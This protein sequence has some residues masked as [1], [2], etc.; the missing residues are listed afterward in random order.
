MKF[1][2][3]SKSLQSKS[4]GAVKVFNRIVKTLRKTNIA[5]YKEQKKIDEE[6][7][8]LQTEHK[9]LANIVESNA[10]V[11]NNIEKVLN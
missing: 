10:K 7:K 8:E 9:A 11:I 3:V 5:A 4:I 1:F 6:V 2:K